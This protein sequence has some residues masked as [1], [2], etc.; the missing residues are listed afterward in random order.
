M[1]LCKSSEMTV[2]FVGPILGGNYEERKII[3]GNLF[4]QPQLLK[5]L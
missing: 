2:Q 3:Y 4:I 5:F 1:N